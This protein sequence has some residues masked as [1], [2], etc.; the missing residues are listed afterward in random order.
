M[1]WLPIVIM[2]PAGQ[3]LSC[4]TQQGVWAH[5]HRTHLLLRLRRAGH[6]DFMITEPASRMTGLQLMMKSEKGEHLQMDILQ[7]Q[8]VTPP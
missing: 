6:M 5:D 4:P 1:W 2:Q 3:S 7:L 8:K